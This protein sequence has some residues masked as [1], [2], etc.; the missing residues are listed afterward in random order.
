M[1]INKKLD[2]CDLFFVLPVTLI[3]EAYLFMIE[4]LRGKRDNI[5]SGQ[6]NPE[7]TIEGV[8]KNAHF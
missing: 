6:S 8:A 4:V 3:P 7:K 5:G 1:L 2:K